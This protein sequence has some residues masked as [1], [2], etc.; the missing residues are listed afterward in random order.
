MMLQHLLD[1]AVVPQRLEE[2]VVEAHHHQFLHRLFAEIM[3]DAVLLVFA[4]DIE[5][6]A[7]Q[8]ART[9]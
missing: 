8:G 1:E 4:K 7:V 3:I 9:L 5:H 2:R 6:D